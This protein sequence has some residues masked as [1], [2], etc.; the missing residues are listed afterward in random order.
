L[1]KVRSKAINKNS[2]LPEKWDRVGGKGGENFTTLPDTNIPYT[3]D[4]RAIPYLENPSARHIVVFNN[5]YY[6]AAIDVIKYGNL[7]GLNQT[8][9]ANEK[10]PISEID[11]DRFK[12]SY[13]DYQDRMKIVF[14]SIDTTYGMK[15]TAAT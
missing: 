8:V 2:P 3:Y 1:K 15:E 7:E 9:V 6:F 5:E 14:E 10:T 12:A 13:D 4:Q 11:F